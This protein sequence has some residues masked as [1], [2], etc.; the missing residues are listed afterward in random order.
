MLHDTNIVEDKQSDS[1]VSFLTLHSFSVLWETPFN[2]SLFSVQN[3]KSWQ[4][5]LHFLILNPFNFRIKVRWLGRVT[6]HSLLATHCLVCL[7]AQNLIVF[8]LDPR[9]SERLPLPLGNCWTCLCGEFEKLLGVAG[10]G[11]AVL[12]AESRERLRSWGE[13][14]LWQWEGWKERAGHK[15]Y[16][17]LP[18]A[19]RELNRVGCSSESLSWKSSPL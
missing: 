17:E 11:A 5:G 1:L 7:F 12:T 3:P 6:D 16:K 10:P 9:G 8:L 4:S 14:F 18:R 13:Q 19:Q 2:F 15:W